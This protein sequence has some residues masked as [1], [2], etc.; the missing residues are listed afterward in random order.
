MKYRF[1]IILLLVMIF[2]AC[3]D[4]QNKSHKSTESKKI[5]SIPQFDADSAFQFVKHQVDFGP[6]VPNTTEHSAC[7]QY[8]YGKLEVYCD[9]AMIQSFK[10]R[11]F[12]GTILHAKN[13]IGS[14]NPENYNRVLLCAHWDSRP[15]ADYDPDPANHRKPILGANDGASGVGVL[16]EVARQLQSQSPPVGI[17]IVLFDAEDYGPPQDTQRDTEMDYWGLGSQ[18]W[19]ANPHV[20]GYFAKYGILLDMVGASDA[21]FYMEGFSLYY[22][23]GVLK[24]VWNTAHRIGY[25]NYFYFEEGGYIDD[26][27][28]YINEIINIPTIDII[29]MDKESANSS[30]FEYWHTVKD[31]MDVIDKTTLNVV[32]QTL[33]TVIFEEQ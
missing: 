29:H 7:A 5:I 4:N 11:A 30:F 8:L 17:D 16:L 31:N 21:R 14:F 22:A 2:S 10:T 3:G 24:K 27:H 23:P 9:T 6:R 1:E 20:P 13:I 19:S 26:D 33:L 28:K 15:F 12:D 18:Y 32:G 25:E